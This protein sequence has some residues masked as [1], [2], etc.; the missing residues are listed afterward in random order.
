MKNRACDQTPGHNCVQEQQRGRA[1]PPPGVVGSSPRRAG[2]RTASEHCRCACA[3]VKL[4]VCITIKSVFN[5]VEHLL[6]QPV[7][8]GPG[9]SRGSAGPSSW[10]RP[11]QHPL[12]IS[13]RG[14]TCVTGVRNNSRRAPLQIRT[15]WI[16]GPA[17]SS[18]GHVTSFCR[19]LC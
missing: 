19:T 7:F 10:P 18:A 4:H 6:L 11:L 3:R 1:S 5:K 8:L 14:S 13:A 12:P 2:A 17:Q 16:I 9:P 15:M